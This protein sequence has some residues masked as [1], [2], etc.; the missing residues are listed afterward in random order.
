VFAGKYY[1]RFRRESNIVVLDDDV[2]DVF[3]NSEAVNAA[4]RQYMAEHGAPSK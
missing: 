4:L 3:K 2:A 1:E